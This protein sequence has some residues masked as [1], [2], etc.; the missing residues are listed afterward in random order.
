MYSFEFSTNNSNLRGTE[1]IC[2][3]NGA[4]RSLSGTVIGV[5]GNTIGIRASNGQ[6]Y[7][8]NI[9]SCTNLMSNQPGY[10]VGTGD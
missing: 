10:S 1:N 8:V 9:G 5:N 4:S 7:N 6:Q 3:S 2:S